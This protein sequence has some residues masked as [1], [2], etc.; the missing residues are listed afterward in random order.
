MQSFNLSL[1][2]SVFLVSIKFYLIFKIINKYKIWDRVQS[3][4]EWDLTI[5]F[6]VY[7]TT[8]II[9]EHYKVG[10]WDLPNL[11]LFQELP[12]VLSWNFFSL[13]ILWLLSSFIDHPFWRQVQSSST[14]WWHLWIPIFRLCNVVPTS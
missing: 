1:D 10:T 11:S 5:H 9:L 8:N 4:S 7:N 13:M 12:L 14:C 6:L 3:W 2:T